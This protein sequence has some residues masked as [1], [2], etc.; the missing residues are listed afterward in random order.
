MASVTTAGRVTYRY[1]MLLVSLLLL[2]VKL[3]ETNESALRLCVYSL[4]VNPGKG[5]FSEE[6]VYKERTEGREREREK[7]RERRERGKRERKR[8]ER[9]GREREREERE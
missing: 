7:E 2:K 6:C 1:S 9:E 4:N 5:S 8:G 3:H